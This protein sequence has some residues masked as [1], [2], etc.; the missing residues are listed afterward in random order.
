MKNKATIVL[1]LLLAILGLSAG[2][3]YRYIKVY[4]SEIEIQ[5]HTENE[6]QSLH[7]KEYVLF[8]K[9][10]EQVFKENGIPAEKYAN[11]TSLRKRAQMANGMTMGIIAMSVFLAFWSLRKLRK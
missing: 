6:A 7:L 1:I 5:Y 10:T 4:S 3:Y 11:N 2:I 9:N 8:L